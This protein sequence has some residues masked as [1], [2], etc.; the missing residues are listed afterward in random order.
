MHKSKVGNSNKM[1]LYADKST[2]KLS[3]FIG[4]IYEDIRFNF[5]NTLVCLHRSGGRLINVSPRYIHH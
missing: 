2:R 5:L 3:T 1:H 4:G